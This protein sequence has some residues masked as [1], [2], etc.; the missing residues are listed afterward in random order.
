MTPLQRRT[1]IAIW[2]LGR[3]SS[4]T[5]RPSA[6]FSTDDIALA[7]GKSY[8]QADNVLRNLRD[9]TRLVQDRY[10]RWQLTRKG[11]ELLKSP[12]F[13]EE[14]MVEPMLADLSEALSL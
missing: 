10:G 6:E 9:R 12:E 3:R 13:F 14:H 11:R 7:I 8:R 2:S 1:L 4:R 5:A